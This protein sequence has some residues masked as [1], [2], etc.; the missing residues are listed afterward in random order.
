VFGLLATVLAAM[1]LYGVLASLVA[2]R[3]REIGLRVALGAPRRWV[4]WLVMRE[5]LTL[6]V[7]GLL[8]G[9]P[10]A[11]LLSRYVASQLFGVTP[12]DAWTGLAAIVMLAVV[13]AAAGFVPARRA[14]A[15]DPIAALRYE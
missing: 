11:Y 15:L 5:V 14:S 9:V 12:S 10:A 13:A 6:L 7:A 8:V 2:R 1:G 3:T 4:M